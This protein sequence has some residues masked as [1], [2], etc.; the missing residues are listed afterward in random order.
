MTTIRYYYADARNQPVGPFAMDDLEKMKDAGVIDP[1]T[2]VCP[3]GGED[4]VTFG[5]LIPGTSSPAPESPP[6]RRAPKD[7]KRDAKTEMNATAAAASA[8]IFPVLMIVTTLAV[9][10]NPIIFAMERAMGTGFLLFLL[11]FA[12]GLFGPIN[13]FKLLRIPGIVGRRTTAAVFAWI[14][15]ALF[16]LALGLLLLVGFG[17]EAEMAR[18]SG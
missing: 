4:W 18:R 12:I 1:E 11:F 15:I 5:S 3:E 16:V 14:G 6:S 8:V 2:Q 10:A 9:A 17:L 13:A 7:R